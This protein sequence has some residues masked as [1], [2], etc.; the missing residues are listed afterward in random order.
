MDADDLNKSPSGRDDQRNGLAGRHCEAVFSE[1]VP[2]SISTVV[3]LAALT[4]PTGF[5]LQ[6]RIILNCGSHLSTPLPK[7]CPPLFLPRALEQAAVGIKLFA[8]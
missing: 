5:L 3:E 4:L 7:S 2:G 1:L 6:E 8:D